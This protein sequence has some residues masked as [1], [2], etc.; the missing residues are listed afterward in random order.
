MYTP[1]RTRAY[2]KH[3]HAAASVAVS[4][5]ILSWPLDATYHVTLRIY[6]GTARKP[7]AD[8]VFKAITDAATGVLWTNDRTVGGTF[9]P[10][11]VSEVPRV[12]VEVVAVRPNNL[13]WFVDTKGERLRSACA[14]MV[15]ARTS[16]A[17][18]HAAA[19]LMALVGS[20][21]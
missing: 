19:Q 17:R 18:L 21:V 11:Q 2:E 10:A 4:G 5:R 6:C 20:E 7:D 12:E 1:P 3:A 9:F 8:N 14:A 15:A 13:R 16:A